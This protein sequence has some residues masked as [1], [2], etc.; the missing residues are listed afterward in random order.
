MKQILI[1]V[2][3]VSII[4]CNTA[5]KA[6]PEET[7]GVSVTKPASIGNTSGY[8]AT[9]ST[10]FEIGDVKNAE[11]ILELWKDWDKGDL[12][13]SK[14]HFADSVTFHT[15]DGSIISG[16]RDSAVTNAQQYRDMFSTVK[17]TLHAVFPIKSIDKNEEWVCLWGTEVSTDK[18]GKTDSVYLQETWRF[19]KEG[20]IDL[21]YQYSRIAKP[22]AASK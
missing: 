7:K 11:T 13:P 4:G 21:L 1:L 15:G 6:P 20:K 9:Y 10:S 22:Q 5:E 16:S 14:M 18:K 17:T 12:S 2:I 19:N 8:T 3:A